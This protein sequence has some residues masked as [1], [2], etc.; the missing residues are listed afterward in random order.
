MLCKGLGPVTASLSEET[1]LSPHD[2]PVLAPDKS[3][4]DS[5][6]GRASV[7]TFPNTHIHPSHRLK[8]PVQG[9]HSSP[10]TVFG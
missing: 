10:S 6:G 2:Q 1:P 7:S 9:P 5:W 3:R 8:P 4:E